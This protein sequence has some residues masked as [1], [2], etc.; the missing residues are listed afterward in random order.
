MKILLNRCFFLN[1][2]YKLIKGHKISISV[3]TEESKL[4]LV[5]FL[6]NLRK[7][8]KKQLFLQGLSFTE[9]F[10]FAIKLMLDILNKMKF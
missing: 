3:E 2:I 6:R 9:I 5:L 8:Q 7:T 4:P 1:Y 10:F